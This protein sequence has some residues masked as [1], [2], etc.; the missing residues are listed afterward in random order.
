WQGVV[1]IGFLLT[2]FSLRPDLGLSI[3]QTFLS[4]KAS[5][6]RFCRTCQKR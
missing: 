2:Y 1:G 3:L 6:S 5:A 4:W